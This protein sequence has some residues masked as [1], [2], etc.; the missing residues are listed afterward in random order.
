M[1]AVRAIASVRGK[2]SNITVLDLNDC[3]YE[4]VSVKVI[5]KLAKYIEGVSEDTVDIVSKSQL[6][7][8]Y[9]TQ[10][11]ITNI[12]KLVYKVDEEGLCV[13]SH[14]YSDNTNV[15]IPYGVDIL[16]ITAA[17]EMPNIENIT[18]AQ[19][20]KR[21]TGST[22]SGVIT[23]KSVKLLGVVEMSIYAFSDCVALESVEFSTALTY[24][25]RFAF[26]RCFS[27]EKIVLPN[28]VILVEDSAFDSCRRLQ[29]VY[30][31]DSIA[32]INAN[33]FANCDLLSEVRMPDYLRTIDD[34]AFLNCVSL[35]ELRIPDTVQ[36]ISSKAF[37]GIPEITLI[38]KKDS[39]A[40]MMA[41]TKDNI[42]VRYEVS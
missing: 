34:N 38:C 16:D 29:S 12:G 10:Y 3:V 39:A 13:L 2:K 11:A 36:Y 4:D 31:P 37:E 24:V 21:I 28:N 22:F 25:G 26:A 23:L 17:K 20:V 18:V 32:V 40:D 1:F 35:K 14:F 6:M 42:K 30:L 7:D 19:T 15:T 41:K 33:V 8:L 27:L 5:Y 9:S